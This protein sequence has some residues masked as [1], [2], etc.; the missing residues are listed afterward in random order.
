M[1]S[2]WTTHREGISDRREEAAVDGLAQ[3]ESR[4][5]RM[6]ACKV[7]QEWRWPRGASADETPS[8]AGRADPSSALRS[9]SRRRRRL[10]RVA[11]VS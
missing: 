6:V 4:G 9:R 5:Q 11:Q 2:C 7:V 10:L 8:N 1:R 3:T